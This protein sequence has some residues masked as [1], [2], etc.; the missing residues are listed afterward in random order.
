LSPG[1]WPRSQRGVGHAQE[2]RD[3]GK[4]VLLCWMGRGKPG[5]WFRQAEGEG[6]KK[7]KNREKA[8]LSSMRELTG[9]KAHL[10][11]R[12]GRGRCLPEL[13]VFEA[14]RERTLTRSGRHKKKK[15]KTCQVSSLAVKKRNHHRPSHRGRKTRGFVDVPCP[16]KVHIRKRKTPAPGRSRGGEGG[17]EV[18]FNKG[19]GKGQPTCAP[20]RYRKGVRLEWNHAG[21]DRPPHTTQS[22]V[23]EKGHQEA[24]FFTSTGVQR[25]KKG[26]LF[27]KKKKKRGKGTV[28]DDLS[29]EGRKGEAVLFFIRVTL[30]KRT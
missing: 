18:A 24:N 28:G 11:I 13:A 22:H 7:E 12:K 30:K 10:V 5:R 27:A 17:L 2:R 20:S 29:W 16:C 3:R 14:L 1:R 23:K 15:K 25:G 8:L 21:E 4:I 19:K 26:T 6:K 9:G